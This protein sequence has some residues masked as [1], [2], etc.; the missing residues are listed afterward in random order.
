MLTK[1][2]WRRVRASTESL[3]RI[4]GRRREENA[5]GAQSRYTGVARSLRYKDVADLET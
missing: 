2:I 4:A 3:V 1:R 5:G